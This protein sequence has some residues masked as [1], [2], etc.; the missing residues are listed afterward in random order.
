MYNEKVYRCKQKTIDWGSFD[1][2]GST[3]SGL[4]IEV[5]T[6]SGFRFG[7]IIKSVEIILN[8]RFVFHISPFQ[9]EGSN[10]LACKLEK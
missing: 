10:H 1:N 8:P 2:I 9:K 4:F 5:S 6:V 3:L 7:N